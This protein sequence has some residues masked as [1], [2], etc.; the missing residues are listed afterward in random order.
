MALFYGDMITF[1]SKLMAK[2]RPTMMSSDGWP[3]SHLK[4]EGLTE[5]QQTSIRVEFDEMLCKLGRHDYEY[6][7]SFVDD[8]D[9][10]KFE[11]RCFHCGAVKSGTQHND[12]YKRWR[13]KREV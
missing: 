10:Q 4:W 6:V 12:E 8:G 3:L 7:D 5:E 13:D 1:W 2:I 9:S 11:L